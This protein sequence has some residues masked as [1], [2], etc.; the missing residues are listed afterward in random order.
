[1]NQRAFGVFQLTDEQ[2][3]VAPPQEIPKQVLLV[4]QYDVL[5]QLAQTSREC[6]L[7]ERIGRQ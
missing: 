1:M 4:P 7:W 2:I 3:H 5:A 6:G